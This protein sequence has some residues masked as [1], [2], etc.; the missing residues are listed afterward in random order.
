M[1][2][3]VVDILNVLKRK[4]TC[5]ETMTVRSSVTVTGFK[6][7]DNYFHTNGRAEILDKIDELIGSNYYDRMDCYL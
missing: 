5:L 3:E 2:R 4:Y 7:N 1:R 6:L